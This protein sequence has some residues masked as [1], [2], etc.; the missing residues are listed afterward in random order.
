LENYRG[1]VSAEEA[2]TPYVP[3]LMNAGAYEFSRFVLPKYPVLAMQARIQGKVELRFTL[4]PDTG[5]VLSVEAVS[6]H[7][8]LKPGA[9]DAAKEWRFRPSSITSRTLRLTLDYALRCP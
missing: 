8:L 2:K 5:E 4:E 6:G 9:V 1:P 3:Q 7:P